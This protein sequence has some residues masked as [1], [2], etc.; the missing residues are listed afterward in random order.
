MR[1]KF[2]S[3]ALLCCALG[4]FAIAADAP[5][6]TTR[7]TPQAVFSRY[8]QAIG[9]KDAVEQVHTAHLKAEMYLDRYSPMPSVWIDRYEDENGRFYQD[10]SDRVAQFRSGYDGKRFWFVTLRSGNLRQLKSPKFGEPRS[11][12]QIGIINDLIRS[13]KSTQVLGASQVGQSKAIVIQATQQ[14]GDSA[15]YYFDGNTG[16]LVRTDVPVRLTNYGYD[17]SERKDAGSEKSAFIDTCLLKQYEP[18]PQ[19]HVLFPRET[20]CTGLDILRINRLTKIEVNVPIDPR[21][22]VQP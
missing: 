12:A 5:S 10:E 17:G 7:I 3:G 21:K 14:D 22:F 6:A 13:S 11:I 4:A 1:F 19:S 9:G 20:E 16:L 18:E 15:L 8:I 2:F